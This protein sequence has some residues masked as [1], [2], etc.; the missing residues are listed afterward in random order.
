MLTLR[1]GLEKAAPVSHEMVMAGLEQTSYDPNYP[2]DD[3]VRDV[4][5]AMLRVVLSTPELRYAYAVLLSEWPGQ[6]ASMENI[7]SDLASGVSSPMVLAGYRV[8]AESGAVD[9][10]CDS[11]QV[12]V[13]RILV[14]ALA[15]RAAAA[16][17]KQVPQ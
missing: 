5:V 15:V 16:V 3:M 12:L 4:F 14:A 8:L 10:V 2:H 6:V 11:D 7:I 13:R 17:A 1:D 9:H